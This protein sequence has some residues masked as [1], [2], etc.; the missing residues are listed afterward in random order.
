MKE[1]KNINKK[2]LA[3]IAAM[4]YGL[5]GFI[6]AL[7]AVMA[8]IINIVIKNYSE[9]SIV[10]ITLIN[11]GEGLLLAILT[12]MLTAGLGWLIGFICS[13][14]YNWFSKKY[15]GI[16]VELADA[17]ETREEEKNKDENKYKITNNQETI[18]KQ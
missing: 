15:G 5:G 16:R 10:L 17:V 3:K 6:A 7:A 18:T 13:G 12:G 4:M 8:T 14:I 1:I 2:S 9:E 11:I